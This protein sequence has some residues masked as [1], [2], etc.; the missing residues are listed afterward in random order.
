MAPALTASRRRWI[1]VLAAAGISGY[2][3]YRFYHLP[4]VSAKRRKL[5]KLFTAL[6]SVAEAIS[7]SADAVSLLTSDLKH[8][9]RSDSDE[10]P[11]SLKQLAKV[12]RSD[13]FSTSISRLSDALAVGV[14]RGLH[15]ASDSPVTEAQ[16]SSSFSDR[17]LDK[18]FSD[19]GSGFAS[20]VVGSFAR[21]MV[22]AL[23]CRGDAIDSCD[24]PA[25][26][27]LMCTDKC[28][29]LIASSI[30]LF[31]RTA[32][33]VYLDKT[34]DVNTYEVLFSGLTNPR[35]EAKVKDIL[36]SVCNGAVETVVKTS[37]GV[38]SR[39]KSS[40]S[41]TS[42]NDLNQFGLFQS[43]KSSGDI[44][45]K[46]SSGWVEQVSS[47]LAV[48]SNRQFVLDVTG[49]VTFESVR[50]FVKFV[51][52]NLQDG[53][54]RSMNVVS[55]KVVERGMDVMRY[56]CSKAMLAFSLCIALCLDIAGGKRILLA[57]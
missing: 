15:T 54:K 26:V 11:L 51:M 8:F 45:S 33:S 34:M 31:V 49:R 56:L 55:E 52:W 24:V 7:S 39:S 37:H 28:R 4:S 9:L 12:A 18:L 1:F 23:Y 57:A 21:S 3:A 14:I 36:V 43:L 17:L 46:Y 50:S 40:S 19:K 5:V 13:E 53:M 41:M 30:Q 35:H 10:I 25:W 6:F 32:V 16:T 48:P 44:K 20:V 42:R 47:V 29:E 38:L 27:N 22:M 2:G